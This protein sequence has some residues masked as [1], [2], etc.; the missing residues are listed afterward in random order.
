MPPKK[1]SDPNRPKGRTS[2]YAYFVAH[3]RGE[4]KK[5]G[6]RVDFAAFSR[7]CS[8]KWKNMDDD[9][10]EEFVKDADLDK[11]RYEEEMK[12]YVRP[13]ASESGRRS[14]KKKDPNAPKRPL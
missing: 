2:A 13:A 11:Q 4:Y 9:K 6:K 1:N 7:E 5:E 12:R 8:R 14:R 3:A 10:K